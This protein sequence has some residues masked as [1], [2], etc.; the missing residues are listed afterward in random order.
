[1][2]ESWNERAGGP[3]RSV[4][5]REEGSEAQSTKELSLMDTAGN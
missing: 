5:P 1:M 4:T 3:C 2:A